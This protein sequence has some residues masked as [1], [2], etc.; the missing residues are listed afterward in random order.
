MIN[1]R[2]MKIWT[3]AEIAMYGMFQVGNIWIS[4][5]SPKKGSFKEVK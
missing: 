5:I 3:E 1:Y 2:I 4:G